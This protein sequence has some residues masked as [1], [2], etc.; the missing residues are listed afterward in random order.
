MLALPPFWDFVTSGLEDSLIFCWLGLCWWLLAGLRPDSRGRA[1]W[2][3]FVAGLGWLVRPD[4]AI[5]TVAF[6]A[7]LWYIVRPGWRRWA[8][9][10]VIAG[11]VPLAYQVFRMGYY[12]LLVPNTAVAKDASSTALPSGIRLPRG[13]RLALPPVD[14][15][16]RPARPLPPHGSG[17]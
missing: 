14:S 17:A 6:L 10:A 12:G 3:A 15:A 16:A 13:F 4:M 9:L 2:L 8:L 1:R 5:G 7:A 11:A